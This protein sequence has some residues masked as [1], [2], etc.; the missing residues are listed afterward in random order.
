MPSVNLDSFV[1]NI[2][3]LGEMIAK[4]KMFIMIYIFKHFASLA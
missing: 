1:N 3:R 4:L 2:C